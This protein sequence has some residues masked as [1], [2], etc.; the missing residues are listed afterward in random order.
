MVKTIIWTLK[1]KNELVDI[2]EYWIFRNKSNTFSVKL[3][4]LIQVQ[5][6]LVAEFPGIGRTTDIPGVFVKIIQNYFL[7]YEIAGDNLYILAIRHTSKNP[8][9]LRLK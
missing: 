6:K 4:E 5:M 8:K 1:A 9:T 3:N 2:L 7:Y